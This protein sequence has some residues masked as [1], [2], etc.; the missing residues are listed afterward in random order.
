MLDYTVHKPC[1][2]PHN[3]SYSFKNLI[4]L[5]LGE[6]PG[7]RRPPVAGFAG[8]FPAGFPA[9]ISDTVMDRGLLQGV[10]LNPHVTRRS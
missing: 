6:A 10:E 9:G 1:S 7:Y 5:T 8:G 4:I 2:Q 3:H